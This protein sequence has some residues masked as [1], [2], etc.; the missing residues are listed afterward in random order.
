MSTCQHRIQSDFQ[1]YQDCQVM[2]IKMMGI[3]VTCHGLEEDQQLQQVAVSD[4]CQ[5]AVQ[6]QS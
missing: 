3:H 1:D 2:V 6:D 4:C 5:S